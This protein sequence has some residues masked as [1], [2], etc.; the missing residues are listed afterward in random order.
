M[1]APPCPECGGH[2]RKLSGRVG[3]KNDENWMCEVAIAERSQGG[4]GPY[5]HRGEALNI[6][7]I[8]RS[9]ANAEAVAK[10]QQEFMIQYQTAVA[11]QQAGGKEAMPLAMPRRGAWTDPRPGDALVDRDLKTVYYVDKDGSRRRVDDPDASK[12]AID[13]IKRQLDLLK[14]Q[15]EKARAAQQTKKDEPKVVLA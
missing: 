7:Y 4:R 11:A 9:D 10:E 12:A 2:M 1:K 8:L 5:S 3:R 6:V 15:Q 13:E 14:Q